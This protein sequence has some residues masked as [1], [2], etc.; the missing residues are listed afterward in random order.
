MTEM[1]RETGTSETLLRL[2]KADLGIS[3]EVKDEYF[4][5]RLEAAKRELE[6]KG[7][8]LNEEETDDLLLISDYAAWLYRKRQEN[9]PMARNLVRRIRNKIVKARAGDAAR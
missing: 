9:I 2:F 6:E 1:Q 4:S 5:R 8:A 3:S 7:I